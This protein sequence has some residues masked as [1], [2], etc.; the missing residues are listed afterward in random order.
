M[1]HKNY[2]ELEPEE[3]RATFVVEGET[4]VEEARGGTLELDLLSLS[5]F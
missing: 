4:K 2:A 5:L 3:I 1:Q